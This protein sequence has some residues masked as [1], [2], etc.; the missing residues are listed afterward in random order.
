MSPLAPDSVLFAYTAGGNLKNYTFSRA[1]DARYRDRKGILQAASSG[2]PRIQ[3]DD[4]N[5]TG[6]Y[7]TPTLLL[8]RATTNFILKSEEFDDAAWAVTGGLTVTANQ[9]TAPD[10]STTAD[11]LENSATEPNR[12]I[13]Q[14]VT[15]AATTN[16]YVASVWVKASTAGDFITI[17]LRDKTNSVWPPMQMNILSGPGT[18]NSTA[19]ATTSPP[20]IGDLSLE[21]WTQVQVALTP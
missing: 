18:A 21:R 1:S 9:T 10:G 5:T 19:A 6:V 3:W 7:D 2:I 13:Q 4:V 8:E 14:A 16:R 17:G 20:T 15:T 12:N 11:L